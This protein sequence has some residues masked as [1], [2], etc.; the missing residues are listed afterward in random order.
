[1]YSKIHGENRSNIDQKM[2]GYK[3]KFKIDFLIS[4]LFSEKNN[5]IIISTLLLLLNCVT[6][7]SANSEIWICD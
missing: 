3:K 1:M 2:I 6:T 5:L 7:S 4:Q